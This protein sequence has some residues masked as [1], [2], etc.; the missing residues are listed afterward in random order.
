MN[1][2]APFSPYRNFADNLRALCARH[3]SIAAVCRALDMNRQQFNKYL[4]GSTLPNAASLEK[5]CAFLD[6]DAERLFV[7]PVGFAPP[8]H[9]FQATAASPA[10]LSL[11]PHQLAGASFANMQ[12]GKLPAGSYHF[13]HAWPR[14]PAKCVRAALVVQRRDGLTHFTRFTK[15]RPPAPRPRRHLSSRHDGLVIDSEKACFFLSLRQRGAG[16]I[17]LASFSIENAG[18]SE[19]LS[20]LALLMGPGGAPMACRAA[21]CY[22]GPAAMLR[23]ALSEASI[24]PLAD[25][26]VPEEVRQAIAPPP[27]HAAACI[28]PFSL[29]DCVSAAYDQG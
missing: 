2:H 16:E 29:L 18:N 27:R 17:S 13:Y 3:G 6:I 8:A 22:R 28:E 19:T 12:P 4:S 26:S 21:L 25:N 5:I 9:G 1:Q 20:G 10:G 11:L 7:D 14:D 23:H 24:L 15:L